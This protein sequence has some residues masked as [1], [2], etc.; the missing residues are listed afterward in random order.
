VSGAVCTILVYPVLAQSKL[1][2]HFLPWLPAG[3]AIYAMYG[4]LLS[5]KRFKVGE[6]EGPLKCLNTV[7][8]IITLKS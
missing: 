5:D 1:A 3:I 7:V 2:S 4:A 8:I 6:M